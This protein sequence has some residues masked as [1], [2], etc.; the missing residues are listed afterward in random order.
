MRIQTHSSK[1][2]GASLVEMA[3]VMPVLLLVL[4]GILELGIAFRDI[5][6]ASQAAREGTRIAAFAGNDPDAD[7]AVIQGLS[8]FLTTYIDKLER[9][10]IYRTNAAGQQVPTQTNIYTFTV[11]DPADCTDWNSIVTWPSTDRQTTVGSQPLDI[12]GVRVKLEHDWITGFPPFSGSFD[13]D[14]TDI[15]RMEPEA[16]E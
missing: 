11:G 3:I 6:G 12:I 1:E 10:E 4:I 7:C 5:L 13:I 9:V 16:F 14:E 2:R 15:T 8:P